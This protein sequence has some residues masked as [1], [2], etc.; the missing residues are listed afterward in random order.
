M[1]RFREYFIDAVLFLLVL[2]GVFLL[3]EQM[4][5]RQTIIVGLQTILDALVDAIGFAI[6]GTFVF[7]TGRSVSDLLGVLLITAFSAAIFVRVRRR[8]LRSVR[9]SGKLCPVCGSHLH[10]VHRTKLDHLISRFLP[11]K[12]YACDN[13][14]CGWSGLRVHETTTHAKSRHSSTRKTHHVTDT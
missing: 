1:K 10:R 13:Q 14:T 12:R 3:V 8:I 7:F 6:D 2:L 9:L 4:S 5:I 11:V